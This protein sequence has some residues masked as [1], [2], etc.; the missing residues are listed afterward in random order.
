MQKSLKKSQIFN[1][2]PEPADLQLYLRSGGFSSLIKVLNNPPEFFIEEIKSSGLRGRGGNAFPTWEKLAASRNNPGEKQIIC[3]ADDR[4]GM[5]K[6][7]FIMTHSAFQLIEGLTIT[8]YLAGISKGFLY[9]RRK[10]RAVQEKLQENISQAILAGYLGNDIQGSGYDLTLEII[11][12]ERSNLC[13]SEKYPAALPESRKGE[14]RSLHHDRA[15]SRSKAVLIYNAETLANIP[16]IIENGSRWFRSLGTPDSPG[17]KLISLSGDIQKSGLYEVPFGK[18]FAQVI[19]EYGGGIKE[20]RTMKAANVGGTSGVLIPREKLDV[21]LEYTA[22]EKAGIPIR[23]GAIFVLDDTRCIFENIKNRLKFYKY[24]SCGRCEPCHEGLRCIN[25][26]IYKLLS[27]GTEPKDIKELERYMSV[28]KSDS[29]CSFG[30]ITGENLLSLISYFKN[31]CMDYCMKREIDGA[32][33]HK[34]IQTAVRWEK[35]R[36]HFTTA[37]SEQ[38][39]Y[40]PN[41]TMESGGKYAIIN[42]AIIAAVK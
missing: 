16:K 14:C 26:I 31:E 33:C 23:S 11:S 37:C 32:F 27:D 17:T 42:K 1:N 28:M 38:S 24:R 30:E 21:K 34:T 18:T 3:N 25:L 15:D 20:G 4:D 29:R 13:E 22:C 40:F 12:G 9:I 6:D 41:N 10:Y 39:F 5:C 36:S 19:N 35:T 8:A 7:R 2:A